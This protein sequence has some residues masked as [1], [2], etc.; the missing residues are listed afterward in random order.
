[1]VYNFINLQMLFS[2]SKMHFPKTSI[3]FHEVLLILQDSDKGHLFLKVFQN[4]L[5]RKGLVFFLCV[6]T[7][8][9]VYF[10]QHL[11]SYTVISN[12]FSISPTSL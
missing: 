9:L 12:L 6:V 2:F 8:S 5:S 3:N 11:A 1:M 4:S 7:A 10:T